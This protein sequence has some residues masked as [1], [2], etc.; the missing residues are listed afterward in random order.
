M[1]RNNLRTYWASKVTSCDL[2]TDFQMDLKSYFVISNFRYPFGT[3]SC[4]TSVRLF[5]VQNLDRRHG[6]AFEVFQA[7][8]TAGGDVAHLLG[9]AHL[10]DGRGA[11]ASADDAHR[12]RV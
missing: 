2:T 12:A 10:L 7:G 9:Q 5:L 6:L 1:R 4:P 8:A 3:S 11:V